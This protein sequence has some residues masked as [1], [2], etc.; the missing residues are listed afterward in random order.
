MY[1][2]QV[3]IFFGLSCIGLLCPVIQNCRV[4]PSVSSPLPVEFGPM[5]QLEFREIDLLGFTRT[6]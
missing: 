2:G 4:E 5:D 6:G 1:M 3:G